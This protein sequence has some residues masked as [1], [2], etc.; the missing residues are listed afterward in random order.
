MLK[1][2]RQS[3]IEAIKKQEATMEVTQQVREARKK[4][5]E[6]CGTCWVGICTSKCLT[7]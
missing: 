1:Q 7:K 2:H 5:E 6:L 4:A 3:E